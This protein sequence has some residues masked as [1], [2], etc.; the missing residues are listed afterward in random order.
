MRTTLASWIALALTVAAC[1]KD[2]SAEP[3]DASSGVATGSDVAIPIIED[4]VRVWTQ[5]HLSIDL[6]AAKLEGVVE[7]ETPAEAF[8]PYKGYRVVLTLSGRM[9]NRIEFQFDDTKPSVYQL[10]KL[11]GQPTEVNKGLIYTKILHE[12]VQVTMLAIPV[13][14][15]AEDGTLIKQLRIEGGPLR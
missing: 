4:A 13:S 6:V 9:V 8:L 7:T 3:S 5:D 11:F 15:P 2:E 14:M 1:S 10:T 12:R